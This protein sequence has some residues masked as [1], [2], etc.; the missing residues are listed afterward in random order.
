MGEERMKNVN[1]KYCLLSEVY[2]GSKILE[3]GRK[4]QTP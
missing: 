3:N 4:R 2:D 1:V